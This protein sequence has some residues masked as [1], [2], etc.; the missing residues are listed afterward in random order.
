[1]SWSWKC[2]GW[3]GYLVVVEV[4]EEA[5]E[6]LLKA[7]CLLS[8]LVVLMMKLILKLDTSWYLCP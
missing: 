3:L 8:W 1:M 5:L 4:K 7:D 6:C 2:L